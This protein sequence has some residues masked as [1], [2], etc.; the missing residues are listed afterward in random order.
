M[1][2]QQNPTSIAQG[3][4]F[5]P[6]L[7]DLLTT[8]RR[9]SA[10]DTHA[11]A[12][13]ERNIDSARSAACA[14]AFLKTTFES[15]RAAATDPASLSRPLMG[16]AVS[17]KDLFDVVGEVTTAGSTLLRDHPPAACDSPVV[18][19][20]RRAGAAIIGRTNMTEFAFSGVGVNP[21]Y[22]TPTNAVT[23]DVPRIPGGSSSG[24]AVSVATGA[25]WIA[26]GSD[27]GGSIR[28][29]AALNG[30]VGFKSTARLVPSEG[31]VPL[32]S[33]LDTVCAITRSVDD[34]ILAHQI[35]ANRLVTR[36]PAP[37]SAYRLAVVRTLMHDSLDPAV[38]QA[39]QRS[40]DML[41]R[42][43][44]DIEEIDLV[45]LQELGPMQATGGFSAAESH[46]WHRALL[47]RH[48]TAYDPRVL[49]RIARGANMWPATTST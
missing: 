44:A 22:G 25:A 5:S 31:A 48:A 34:A 43:G 24:A 9:L 8:R 6:M 12:E 7:D 13:L 32:S 4:I 30:V 15:A 41:R 45:G 17:V 39:Y 10:G 40:L 14:H 46:A 23:T 49:L 21:H 33:T 42:A 2:T 20:L 18:S 27:T 38:A 28:I 16:L 11:L 1:S 47:A 19:R 35:L 29:P 26:L 37:L 36:S 3:P